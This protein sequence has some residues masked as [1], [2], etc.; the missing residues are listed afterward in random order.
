MWLTYQ[1]IMAVRQKAFI[2]LHS[3]FV[4]C[5]RTPAIIPLG[6]AAFDFPALAITFACFDWAAALRR[7]LF[8]A[9]KGR[10]GR[11]DAP[12]AQALAKFIAMEQ[13]D[14]NSLFRR[15]A[16]LNVDDSVWDTSTFSTQR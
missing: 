6:K 16:G 8:V 13:F 14:Y 15:F 9:F 12:S 7:A 10:N 1:R 11:L 5:D 4:V 2:M 3:A